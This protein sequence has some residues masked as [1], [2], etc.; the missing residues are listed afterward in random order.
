MS[1]TSLQRTASK[2]GRTCKSP[3]NSVEKQLQPEAIEAASFQGVSA[4]TKEY[5]KT[6]E[7]TRMA[8]A[9]LI[10]ERVYQRAMKGQLPKDTSRLE[11]YS[12]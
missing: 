2:S 4:K 7:R 11:L 9:E 1:T 8:M 3:V 6:D 5:F 12:V 10:D